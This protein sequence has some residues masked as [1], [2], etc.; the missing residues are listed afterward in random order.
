MDAFVIDRVRGE[1]HRG[2]GE[3]DDGD[4]SRLNREARIEGRRDARDRDRSGCSRVG[5]DEQLERG[6]RASQPSIVAGHHQPEIR[7]PA[8]GRALSNSGQRRQLNAPSS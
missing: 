2:V 7:A 4:H 5:R 3:V 6:N 1:R 8:V